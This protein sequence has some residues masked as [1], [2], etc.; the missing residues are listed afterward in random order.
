M[1]KILT[2]ALLVLGSVGTWAFDVTTCGLIIP[3]GGEGVLQNDIDCGG[4]ITGVTIERQGSIKLNGFTIRHAGG[5]GGIYCTD[6]RCTVVGPGAVADCASVDGAFVDS[7]VRLVVGKLSVDRCRNGIN[8]AFEVGN[9]PQ[10]RVL[11]VDLALR[12]N[13]RDGAVVGRFTGRSVTVSGNGLA[14]IHAGRRIVGDQ[15]TA[16]NNGTQGVVASRVKLISSSVTGG[17]I[18]AE[19]VHASFLGSVLTGNATA[20]LVGHK[21][22][23]FLGSSCGHSVR[24]GGAPG[25]TLG[26][27]AS[28]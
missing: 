10:S 7:G 13:T 25:E 5:A 19:F 1:R 12:D 2:L 11:A 15:L 21:R 28:D 22:P 14:G 4:T 20:D 26:V 23:T 6:R 8:S 24:V 3:A 18:G 9:M 17:A 27:C 16:S